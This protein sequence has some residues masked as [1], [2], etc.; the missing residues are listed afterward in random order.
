[1]GP[2]AMTANQAEAAAHEQ[3]HRT[4]DTFFHPFSVPQPTALDMPPI[5]FGYWSG[6]PSY[7]SYSYPHLFPLPTA[8]HVD[9]YGYLRT[10]ANGIPTSSIL[11]VESPAVPAVDRKDI[12]PKASESLE[13][14]KAKERVDIPSLEPDSNLAKGTW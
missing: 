11:P 5:P 10:F 9:P 3:R 13:R 8:P 6:H 2:Y 12:M 14:A 4:F 7:P 1:M